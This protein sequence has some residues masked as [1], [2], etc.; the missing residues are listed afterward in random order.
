MANL[1][2]SHGVDSDRSGLAQRLHWL[3]A[4]VS[5]AVAE[6][7]RHRLADPAMRALFVTDED[8]DRVLS[9]TAH[10]AG[11][12]SRDDIANDKAGEA[13]D[14]LGIA[15]GLDEL[16]LRLLVI[17]A[18]PEIDPRFG[19]LY[20]YLQ[21]DVNARRCTVAVAL[22]LAGASVLDAAARARLLPG[23]ALVE[24]GLLALSASDRPLPNRFAVVPDR[25]A[26]AML[27]DPTPSE[28]LQPL[29]TQPPPAL[30]GDVAALA[31]A[32]EAGVNVAYLRDVAGGGTSLGAAAFG[33]LGLQAL[34][35]DLELMSGDA[36][37]LAR[38]AVRDARLNGA[39]IVAGPVE[40][41][42]EAPHALRTLTDS[43]W[44]VILIGK[45]PFDPSW[46]RYVPFELDVPPT[47]GGRGAQAW[48]AFL[49][50]REAPD[51][52]IEAATAPYRLSSEQIARAAAAAL[53]R[54]DLAG[55]P[56]VT[57]DIS[58]GVLAQNSSGLDRLARR[59]TP[60]A[61]WDQLVLPPD[62][63][64]QLR[65]VL[66]RTRHRSLVLEE[67][68]LARGGA[69]GEGVTALFA[70]PSGTGKTMAAEVLA[71]ELGLHLY[72]VDLATVVDKYVGETEKNLDR[73]FGEA[74]RV[75]G[76]LFF[77]EAD[78][79]FGKRSDVRDAHDRYANVEVAYLLQRMETFSGIAVLATN[80]RS[81]I[82]DAFL[83]RLDVIVDFPAPPPELRFRLWSSFAR[84]LPL[85]DELDLEFCAR[86]FEFTGGN[87]R[88]VVM[89]AAYLAAAAGDGVR[90][91]HIIRA[92][93]REHRKLGRL[94]VESE[95]GPYRNLLK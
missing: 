82:D 44:P 92:V 64:D 11:T 20:G 41:I 39:G 31:A 69:R 26:N 87:I 91:G 23:S 52:D 16:D 83:R 49:S 85:A 10:A 35:L 73:I 1:W 7:R 62:S 76:I 78:A 22:E 9:A 80:L 24:G 71:N 68:G 77:D 95:F 53:L 84:S 15:F 59:I 67:W 17:A 90:M 54:A 29:L 60:A 45:R 57:D 12:D 18:A 65:E 3:E 47:A 25:V 33:H 58:A 6:R 63:A 14:R 51:L 34:V 32:I 5:D 61:N 79:L 70:G 66:D 94:V 40:R 30:A 27:G 48:K 37:E 2:S 88:N 74:E 93:Q 19:V 55:R 21:D 13:I 42:A 72:A 43:A 86:A 46:S 89:G 4:R 38:E 56:V 28:I 8:V 50:G 81:N 75:N 36:D